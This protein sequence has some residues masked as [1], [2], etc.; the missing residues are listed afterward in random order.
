MEYGAEMKKFLIFV[1]IMT[2][3]FAQLVTPPTNIPLI[4]ISRTCSRSGGVWNGTTV[5]CECPEG[6]EFD[7]EKG[8][9]NAR[10]QDLCKTTKGIWFVDNRKVPAVEICDCGF[11]RRW[12]DAEG[13]TGGILESIFNF[14]RS[15]VPSYLFG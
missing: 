5:E 3:G 2:V 9:Y 6:F 7:Q 14:F 8:C 13:C 15:L 1:F 4:E 12:D 10:A 11:A